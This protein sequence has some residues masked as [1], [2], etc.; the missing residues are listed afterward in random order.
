MLERV[1]PRIQLLSLAKTLQAHVDDDKIFHWVVERVDD[2][3]AQSESEDD[4]HVHVLT[5]LIF[6]HSFCPNFLDVRM[7]APYLER[8]KTAVLHRWNLGQVHFR[9]PPRK[10]DVYAQKLNTPSLYIYPK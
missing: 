5:D 3:F 8:F 10:T 1:Q 6:S 2:S 4:D 9:G 7:A